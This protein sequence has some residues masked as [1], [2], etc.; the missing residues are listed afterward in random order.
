MDNFIPDIYQKSIYHIDYDKL[1]DDGIKCILFDLDNTCAP[2]KESE[3]NKR[4][5]DL[6]ETLKDMGFKLVIFSNAPKKR[7]YP[8]KKAL[9]VDCLA[10][11]HKPI[12]KSFL[13]VI[14]LFNYE[15]SEVAIVGDQLYKDILGGNRAGIKTILV[16]PMSNK[17]MLL[18]M[19]IFR[20]LEKI[21][22]KELAKKG[23]LVKGEY[24]E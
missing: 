15:L 24:Y 1:L 6:F 14:N 11:A 3:P 5:I 2:Y 19:L 21:K 18:T 23:L 8:F 7:I 10:R 12:K 22:Y 4:L 20:R 16:N 9:N 17:D 13:K